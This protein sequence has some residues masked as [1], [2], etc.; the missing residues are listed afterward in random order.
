MAEKGDV[1]EPGAPEIIAIAKSSQSDK[2][3][4]MIYDCRE[5]PPDAMVWFKF[6]ITL[7]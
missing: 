2:S 3:S 7:S 4:I 6:T 5:D 1:L